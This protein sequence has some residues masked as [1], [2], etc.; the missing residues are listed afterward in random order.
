MPVRIGTGLPGG[1]RPRQRIS[2]SLAV[3]HMQTV[4]RRRQSNFVALRDGSVAAKLD[5]GGFDD[6]TQIWFRVDSPGGLACVPYQVDYH[7]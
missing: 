2:Y 5:C 1:S 6:G 3:E 7:F 4:D